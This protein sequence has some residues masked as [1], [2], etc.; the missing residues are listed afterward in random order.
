MTLEDLK[1]K[2]ILFDS[3]AHMGFGGYK[4][5]VK[6]ISDSA[7][8]S[9]V[10]EIFDIAVDLK[11]SVEN[12]SRV[13]DFPNLKPLVGIDPE[14]LIPGSEM[15]LNIPN[16]DEWLKGEI[17]KLENLIIENPNIIAGIGETGID[18]HHLKVSKKPE[19]EIEESKKI[20]EKLFRKQIELAQKYDL[21][22]SIHSRGAEK[23][24]LEILKE[25]K[26]HGIFHSFTGSYEVAEEILKTS[27]GLGV[28]GIITFRNADGLRHIYKNIIGEIPENVTPSFF[29]RKGIF[30]ETDAPFLAPEGKRG[31]VNESANI[32]VIYES[33]V[34]SLKS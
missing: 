2:E 24:C 15:Y 31:E 13:K 23:E 32:K 3:H 5:N 8:E 22:L 1:T 11:T 6:E 17:E 33:F 10:L 25:Y 18:L 21:F 26:A 16:I 34:N 28:N 14:V 27:N 7:Q 20:Q 9:G 19:G 29:Y 4:K 30:F 12:L